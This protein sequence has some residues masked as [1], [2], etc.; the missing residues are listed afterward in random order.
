MPSP[1]ATC[2][3]SGLR[4]DVLRGYLVLVLLADLWRSSPTR[5]CVKMNRP[6]HTA[7]EH[8]D[9][10]G[11]HDAAPPG[12]D[13]FRRRRSKRRSPARALRR[14]LNRFSLSGPD[15]SRDRRVLARRRGLRPVARAARGR[16]DRRHGH[17]RPA[18]ARKFPFGTDYLGRDML[19]RILFGARYTVGSRW[20]RRCWPADRRHCCSA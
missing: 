15:R 11:P 3:W 14:M 1:T 4:D 18:S 13:A 20:R 2:R 7:C 17:I 9:P 5:G 16:R 6:E 8:R 10:R 12:A 19:S